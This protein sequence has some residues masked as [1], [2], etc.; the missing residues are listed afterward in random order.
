MSC[1]NY[2]FIT[3]PLHH[4]KTQCLNL[5]ALLLI[6]QHWRLMREISQHTCQ[7]SAIASHP[8]KPLST[9]HHGNFSHGLRE[10]LPLL[11]PKCALTFLKISTPGFS[12]WRWS[13]QN[14]EWRTSGV[15]KLWTVADSA[16]HI[17]LWRM[18]RP[19][20]YLS[21][22]RR[23]QRGDQQVLRPQNLQC[24]SPVSLAVYVHLWEREIHSMLLLQNHS[25]ATTFFGPFQTAQSSWYEVMST[26]SVIPV[27]LK[28]ILVLSKPQLPYI[29]YRMLVS[30]LNGHYHYK[31]TYMQSD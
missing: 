15:N 6:Y 3:F 5:P 8:Q 25:N 24:E 21:R 11:T 23:V 10:C 26:L 19:R 14:S 17:P 28:L 9:W 18:G 30:S 13:F 7:S 16:D 31:T 29:Q 4:C 2:S 12:L 27:P 1:R 22:S 20:I